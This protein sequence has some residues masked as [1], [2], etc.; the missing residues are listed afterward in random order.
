[1]APSPLGDGVTSTDGEGEPTTDELGVAVGAVLGG[2]LAGAVDG[3]S[4]GVVVGPVEVLGE[5][6]PADAVELGVG[7]GGSLPSGTTEIVPLFAD[8]G[9]LATIRRS[10]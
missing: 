8:E 7:A 1:M 3:G 6:G 10:S 5:A 2:G 4:W 9:S